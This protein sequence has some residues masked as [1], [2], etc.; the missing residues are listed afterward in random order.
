MIKKLL[1]IS[2]LLI[3]ITLCAS[4]GF[5]PRSANDIPKELRVIT[6]KMPDTDIGFQSDIIRLLKSL[7]IR[8][9]PNSPIVLNIS[10]FQFTH[11]QPGFTTTTQAVTYTYRI[12]LT[13]SILKNN[14]IL[15]PPTT[16][17][18]IRQVIMNVNQVYTSSTAALAK[19]ELEREVV[20]LLYN[21][22]ISQ[23]TKIA[24]EN[25]TAVNKK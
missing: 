1:A 18:A 14:T 9:E 11:N 8:L 4:C 13:F 16:L 21:K 15:V 3:N 22:L 6:V 12:V 10:S 23:D 5:H 17:S 2:F 25:N 7:H 20:N 19:S 24:L